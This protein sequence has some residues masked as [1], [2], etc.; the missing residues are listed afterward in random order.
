[1]ELTLGPV[2]FE[3]TK[4]DIFG[5]YEDVS[6]MAVDTVY[7]GEVV[8][9]KKKGV[10][11]QD[12]LE[13]GRMLAS[14]GKKV[15]VSTLAVVSNEED[16]GL[17][18]SLVDLPFGV[19]ANDVSALNMVAHGQKEVTTGPHITAYNVP[20][21][22]FLKGIGVKRV[23]FPVELPCDSITRNMRD[24]GVEG[25]V[26]V[27][28]KVPLA[29]SWRCYTLRERGLTKAQC[30]GQCAGHPDGMVIKTLADEPLFTIN[31]TSILSAKTYTLVEF[32]EDLKET[33][34]NAIRVSP[35]HKHTAKVVDIFRARMDGV[36]GAGE[37]LK[38]IEALS[39]AGVCNGWYTAAAG[40]DYI[41]AA[42][43]AQTEVGHG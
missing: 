24:A 40:K 34:I 10:E 43:Y 42:A 2:L 5:F 8:C 6:R 41:S 18:K 21:V 39:G 23:V 9:A 30:R 32:V 7:I 25:E 19:E 37:A 28:G 29:F 38:E 16:L 15:V 31:G 36:M 20:T 1:M 35:Q 26:F 4:K 14:A 13:I 11:P 12:I 33:G 3:W 17:V 27:H 22:R